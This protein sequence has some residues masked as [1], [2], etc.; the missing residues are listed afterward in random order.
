M[1]THMM[2]RRLSSAFASKRK[3]WALQHRVPLSMPKVLLQSMLQQPR[4]PLQRPRIALLQTTRPLLHNAA[5]EHCYRACSHVCEPCESFLTLLCQRLLLNTKMS[6]EYTP[7]AVG[8]ISLARAIRPLCNA[9]LAFGT[10]GLR[11]P[12]LCEAH[13]AHPVQLSRTVVPQTVLALEV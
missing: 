12:S 11:T 9:P 5:T 10:D 3:C 2:S 13:P 8:H 6:S 1:R 7:H 4:Q